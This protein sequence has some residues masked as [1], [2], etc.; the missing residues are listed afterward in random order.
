MIAD[1]VKCHVF[2]IC[3]VGRCRKRLDEHTGIAGIDFKNSVG[4]VVADEKMAAQRIVGCSRGLNRET[5]QAGGMVESHRQREVEQVVD[6][7]KWRLIDLGVDEQQGA[8]SRSAA[9]NKS[10]A[11]RV[12]NSNAVVSIAF[13]MTGLEMLRA[14]GE[15]VD[16]T[17]SGAASAAVVSPPISARECWAGAKAS[18]LASSSSSRIFECPPIPRLR[19]NDAPCAYDREL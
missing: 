11:R 13:T 14:A 1:R 19:I 3:C 2:R 7:K 15:L 12:W 6:F 17:D 18:A 5:F 4:I 10:K 9:R 8:G 16:L